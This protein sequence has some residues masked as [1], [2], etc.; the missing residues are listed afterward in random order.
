MTVRAGFSA[1]TGTS[2]RSTRRTREDR[3]VV[4]MW[5]RSQYDAMRVY[6]CPEYARVAVRAHLYRKYRTRVLAGVLAWMVL[7]RKRRR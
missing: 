4:P 7:T 2:G 3:K 6:R 5:R 1:R